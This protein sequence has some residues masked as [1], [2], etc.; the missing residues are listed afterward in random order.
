MKYSDGVLL[1][2]KESLIRYFKACYPALSQQSYYEDRATYILSKYGQN[3]STIKQKL[4]NVLDENK[5]SSLSKF[6]IIDSYIKKRE[7]AKDEEDTK[8]SEEEKERESSLLKSKHF[9]ISIEEDKNTINA[10]LEYE[11]E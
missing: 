8:E 1:L 11:A 10:T 2:D 6:E 4:S 9:R 3:L 7:A 5:D